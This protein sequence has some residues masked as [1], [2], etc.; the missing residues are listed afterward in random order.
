VRKEAEQR[1]KDKNKNMEPVVHTKEDVFIIK[2]NDEFRQNMLVECIALEDG[3]EHLFAIGYVSHVQQDGL[4]QIKIIREIDS[5]MSNL[6]YQ[7]KK[8][9]VRLG[10]RYDIFMQ[11]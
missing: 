4:R 8:I 7:A 10:V 6:Y 5:K 3:I 2:N 11:P 1:K 9:V